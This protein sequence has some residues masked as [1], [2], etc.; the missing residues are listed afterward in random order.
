METFASFCNI[1]FYVI[2][3]FMLFYFTFC[4]DGLSAAS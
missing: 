4:A 1:P 2:A 3:V